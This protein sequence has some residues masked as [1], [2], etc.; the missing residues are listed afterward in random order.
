MTMGD[1]TRPRLI[2]LPD[3]DWID[4]RLVRRVETWEFPHMVFVLVQIEGGEEIRID[5]ESFEEAQEMRDQIAR[6][7]NGDDAPKGGMT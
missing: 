3:G 4:V 7:V 5:C 6:Q 2:Q 1:C